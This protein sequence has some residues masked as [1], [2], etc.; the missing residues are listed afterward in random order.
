MALDGILLSK[1]IPQIQAALPLRIQKIQDV[2]PTELLFHTHGSGGRKQLLISCHSVYNRLMFTDRS[3]QAPWQP[4]NFVMVLRKYIEGGMI[5]D[6]KQAEL[7][8]WCRMEISRRNNLGD[9]EHI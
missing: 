8:R 7:D 3:Y 4:G 2:S 9:M 6:L 5:T 1:I